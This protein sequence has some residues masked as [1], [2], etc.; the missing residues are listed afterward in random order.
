MTIKYAILGLLSW[1]PF[2]GYD[3]KKIFVDSASLYWSGN[4]NQIYRIEGLKMNKRA[5]AN[6]NKFLKGKVTSQQAIDDITKYINIINDINRINTRCKVIFL[7]GRLF[8]DGN[9]Y[10]ITAYWADSELIQFYLQK[11]EV[12]Q[13]E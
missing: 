6:G 8:P 3:L 9:L 11:T 13:N 5:I 7:V 2:S 10:I 12:L 4:N 1:K